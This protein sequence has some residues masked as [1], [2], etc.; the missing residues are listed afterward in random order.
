MD[1]PLYLF[2]S[3]QG[4]EKVARLAQFSCAIGIKVNLIHLEECVNEVG[5]FHG[6]TTFPLQLGEA[7]SEN[8]DFESVIVGAENFLSL[9][10]DFGLYTLLLLQ[11]VK[12]ADREYLGV[13]ALYDERNAGGIDARGERVNNLE[14]LLVEGLLQLAGGR[15]NVS[16]SFPLL[17]CEM[18]YHRCF[19]LLCEYT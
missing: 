10:E 16:D 4:G 8:L 12:D 6:L 13:V 18:S 7:V 3:L 9:A 1:C 14:T 15:Y 2:R 11:D 17:L 5:R 19:V